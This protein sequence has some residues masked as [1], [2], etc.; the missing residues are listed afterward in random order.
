M[1][2]A[3]FFRGVRV[4]VPSVDTSNLPQIIC[5]ICLTKFFRAKDPYLVHRYH[6]KDCEPLKTAED[7]YNACKKTEASHK[8]PI[9]FL[10]ETVLEFLA[11]KKYKTSI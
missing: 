3:Y 7:Q 1:R 8:M 9:S 2:D 11:K 4:T 6:D 10:N 5:A